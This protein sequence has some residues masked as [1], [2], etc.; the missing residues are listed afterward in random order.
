MAVN[1][2]QFNLCLISEM[3]CCVVGSKLIVTGAA[4]WSVG[5]GA[6]TSQTEKR[7]GFSSRAGQIGHSVAIGSPPLHIF[8][9]LCC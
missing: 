8:L 9:E 7:C 2:R 5:V 3:V 1:L 6:A 4:C